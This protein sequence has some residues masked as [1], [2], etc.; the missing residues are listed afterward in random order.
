MILTLQCAQQHETLMILTLQRAQRHEILQR[1]QQHDTLMTWTLHVLMTRHYSMPSRRLSHSS[2]GPPST[3][4]SSV[5][6]STLVTHT[7][8]ITPLWRDTLMT[9]IVKTTGWTFALTLVKTPNTYPDCMIHLPAPH[10]SI[11]SRPL[12]MGRMSRFGLEVT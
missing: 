8:E 9:D 10:R 4:P 1:A 3:C 12:D 2:S 6:H 7:W 11:S 5:I